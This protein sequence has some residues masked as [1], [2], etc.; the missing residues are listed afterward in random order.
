MFLV[1]ITTEVE[2]FLKMPLDEMKRY[3]EYFH[4]VTAPT[5]RSAAA[6]IAPNARVVWFI[7]FLFSSY[8]ALVYL[9]WG[10]CC[11]NLMLKFVC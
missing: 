5:T 6:K 10:N 8:M 3:V 11:Y 7:I 9:Y 2:D 4:A 1:I